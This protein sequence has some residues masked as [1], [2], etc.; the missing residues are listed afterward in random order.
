M[1][2]GLSDRC[3]YFGNRL[4]HLRDWLG[5]GLDGLRYRRHRLAN[6]RQELRRF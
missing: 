2:G 3:N 4:H 6:S 1:P 5:D